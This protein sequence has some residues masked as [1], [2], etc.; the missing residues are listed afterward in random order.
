MRL[1]SRDHLASRVRI[2]L[3]A[4]LAFTPF[5]ADAQTMVC[6]PNGCRIAERPVA[7]RVVAVASPR[8]RVY[9][10]ASRPR[11]FNR[12][13]YAAPVV[14]SYGSSGAQSYGSQGAAPSY[15]SQGGTPSYYTAPP[16]PPVAEP[17]PVAS[18]PL[19]AVHACPCGANCNCGPSCECEGKSDA[20]AA[21]AVVPA[22]LAVEGVAVVPPATVAAVAF[23]PPAE[24]VSGPYTLAM[25]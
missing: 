4:A 13:L 22:C 14:G 11:V 15:G 10:T 2:L 8:V 5:T 18:P 19:S 25:L 24:P 3:A 17:E 1:S 21:V 6:G 16:Q 20:A 23:V 7:A 12:R 9:T